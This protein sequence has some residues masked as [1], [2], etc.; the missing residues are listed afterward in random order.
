MYDRY[1]WNLIFLSNNKLK[2]F[3]PLFKTVI[4]ETAI[5]TSHVKRKKIIALL[6]STSI[7]FFLA[8]K[9]FSRWAFTRVQLNVLISFQS[10]ERVQHRTSIFGGHV[11]LLLLLD[12]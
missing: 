7:Q 1:Y 5:A 6:L 3:S 10:Q 12:K 9:N 4:L 11:I 8:I 2:L